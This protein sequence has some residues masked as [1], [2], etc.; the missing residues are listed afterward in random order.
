MFLQEPNTEMSNTPQARLTLLLRPLLQEEQR[1]RQEFARTRQ[2]E[3][4]LESDLL[5]CR[6]AMASHD[7]WAGKAA[8]GDDPVDL[9]FYRQCAAELADELARNQTELRA[10]REQ[11]RER[12]EELERR[13]KQRKAHEGLLRRQEALAAADAQHRS[14]REQDHLHAAQLAWRLEHEGEEN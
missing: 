6:I 7:A 12:R 3:Q 11:L 5:R 9:A 4:T 8:R 13:M 14:V 10:V 2:Q 1:A